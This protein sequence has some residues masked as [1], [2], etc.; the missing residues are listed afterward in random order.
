MIMEIERKTLEETQEEMY[1]EMD[2]TNSKEKLLIENNFDDSSILPSDLVY[3]QL[4]P[5][6][7]SPA[8]VFLDQIPRN[9]SYSIPIHT[10]SQTS[11]QNLPSTWGSSRIPSPPSQLSCSVSGTPASSASPSSSFIRRKIRESFSKLLK[12]GSF[13]RARSPGDEQ[14]CSDSEC[15]NC[16]DRRASEYSIVSPATEE[17]V[18]ESLRNGLP[19]IPFAYPT[20]FMAGKNQEDVKKGIRKNSLKRLK[21]SFSRGRSQDYDNVGEEE[22]YEDKSLDSIVRMAKQELESFNQVLYFCT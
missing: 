20:F 19:I 6:L 10:Y 8:T 17:V 18:N 15:Y 21:R 4:S 12:R 11:T 9:R 22:N 2:L 16:E 1:F 3:K 14:A 7:D 13:S 5:N